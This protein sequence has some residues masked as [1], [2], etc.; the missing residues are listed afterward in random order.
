MADLIPGF[1]C[2]YMKLGDLTLEPDFGRYWAL[3]AE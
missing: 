2:E 3:V 1:S